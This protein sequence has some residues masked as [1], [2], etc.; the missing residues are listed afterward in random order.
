MSLITLRSSQQS[1]GATIGE[2][3]ALIR[4]Y[5]KEGIE[6]MPGNALELVSMS[7]TKLEKFEIV[8]GQNDQFIWRIGS[9]PPS[10]GGVPNFSQHK[11]IIPAGSYNGASLAKTIQDATNSSTLLGPYRGQWVCTFTPAKD[12][13]PGGAAGTNAKFTLTYG[14][15]G[16][17][18]SNGEEQTYLATGSGAIS[19]TKNSAEKVIDVTWSVVSQQNNGSQNINNG[20][21]G[22]KSVYAN[23][24]EFFTIIKPLKDI[25]GV[26]DMIGTNLL[27]NYEVSGIA[28]D[29]N[30]DITALVADPNNWDFK[31]DFE[32]GPIGEIK[33]FNLPGTHGPIDTLTIDSGG[34]GYVQNDILDIISSGSPP[35]TGGKLEVNTIDAGGAILSFTITEAG[36]GYV[37]GESC[38]LTGGSGADGIVSVS[39]TLDGD[40]TGYAQNDTGTFTYDAGGTGVGGEYKILSVGGS[41]EVLTMEITDPGQEYAVGDVLELTDSG[42]GGGSGA[43][44]QVKSVE[45]GIVE[46]YGV[47]ISDGV[48]GV[49]TNKNVSALDPGNWDLGR[50]DWDITFNYWKGQASSGDELE[51]SVLSLP[52]GAG[53]SGLVL[54]DSLYPEGRFGRS[55]DQLIQGITQYPGDVQARINS[56]PSGQDVCI[57]LQNTPEQ[58]DIIIQVTGFVK[59]PGFDYPLNGWRTTKTFTNPVKSS[60]WNSLSQSPANWTSFTYGKDSIKIRI[61]QYNI[62]NNRFFISHDTQGD[63]TFIEEVTLLQTSDDNNEKF[64]S[65]VR[66]RLYPYCPTAFVSRGNK[67]DNGRFQLGG[68]FDDTRIT[69]VPGLIGSTNSAGVEHLEA[70]DNLVIE[71]DQVSLGATPQQL[72]AMFKFGIVDQ[73]DIHDGPP[74]GA[75]ANEISNR[76][77]VPNTANINFITGFETA[78]TFQSGQETNSVSTAD[79]RMPETS[80]LEP[81]LHLELPDFNI[82]SYNGESGDTG[83]AVAVIPKEQWTTDSKTGTLQYVAPYPIPIDLRIPNYQ[84]INEINARLRQPSGELAND[85]INPTEICLRLTETYESTQQRVMNNAINRMNS[86]NSNLQDNKISNFNNDMPKI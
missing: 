32:E 27:T 83:R 34:N 69:N 63:G 40:G 50:M 52:G 19:F 68:I 38:T 29:I 17:P 75:G 8:E 74:S 3:A 4:N 43:T 33:T 73:A 56:D 70:E 46:H 84:V 47:I 54:E 2:S 55:R 44:I 60:N 62:R 72:S 39:G 13:V 15:R 16:T 18:P 30:V 23:G 85:L 26:T 35:G 71:D 49:G 9:G 41:G 58:D 57:R 22:N 86:I 61:T 31:M 65:S 80:L 14:Q 82:K 20:I 81:S 36:N 42:A 64:D 53:Y 11:V 12:S 25:T 67:F 66:E 5:F 21:Y 78:Y 1:N 51:N 79:T 28:E 48:L 7:I 45:R 77:E 59:N 37:F 76:S 6:L 10:L 24:G